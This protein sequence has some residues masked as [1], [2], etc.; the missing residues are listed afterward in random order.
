MNTPMQ[1]IRLKCLDCCGNQYSEVRTCSSLDCPLWYHRIGIRP[2]KE[3]L[4][5]N[6]LLSKEFFAKMQNKSAAE[7]DAALKEAQAKS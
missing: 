2:S 6:M 5:K 7:V 1:A 4:A 3:V